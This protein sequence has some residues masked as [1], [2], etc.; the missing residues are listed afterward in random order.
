VTT[1]TG[2]FF[3]P[4]T[5][6]GVSSYAWLW[7]DALSSLEELLNADQ[8]KFSTRCLVGGFGFR[9]I[10]LMSV[11]GWTVWGARLCKN[12]GA[13]SHKLCSC[14]AMRICSSH[15]K[16]DDLVKAAAVRHLRWSVANE[17]EDHDPRSTKR[18]TF[19][20]KHLLESDVCLRC[21]ANQ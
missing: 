11:L 17:S 8:P 21:D 1:G 18:L 15:G 9:A 19:L 4:C 7:P 5:T 6:R 3:R 20:I 2:S 14:V 10:C 13:C 16:L 12:R